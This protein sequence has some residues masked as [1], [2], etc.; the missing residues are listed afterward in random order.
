MA[1]HQQ[2]LGHIE[3][4]EQ[5]NDWL[6]VGSEQHDPFTK[7]S[8]FSTNVLHIINLLSIDTKIMHSSYLMQFI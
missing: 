1:S 8:P 3:G 7:T 5:H 4:L 6:G 2:H